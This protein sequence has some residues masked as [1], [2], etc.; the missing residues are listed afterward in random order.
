MGA[1]AVVDFDEVIVPAQGTKPA[2]TLGDALA[3]RHDCFEPVIA[4]G[5]E[6]QAAPVSG[7]RAR[8]GVKDDA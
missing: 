6:P 2:F 5:D 7:P 3:G 1:G 4:D 8:R